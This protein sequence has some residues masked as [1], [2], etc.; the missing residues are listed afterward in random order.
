MGETQA[1]FEVSAEAD[2]KFSSFLSYFPH[3]QV[4]KIKELSRKLRFAKALYHR[5]EVKFCG[6]ELGLI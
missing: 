3:K 1:R 5:G 4:R 2:C 6:S